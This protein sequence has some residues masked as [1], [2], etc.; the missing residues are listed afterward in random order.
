MVPYEKLTAEE[1]VAQQLIRFDW[2][3]KR[4]LRSKTNFGILEGF[5]SELL[6][7]DLK[8]LNILESEGNKD[9]KDIKFNKVDVLVELAG[10]EIVLI[11][12]K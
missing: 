6:K 8:I 1:K 4:L 11:E 10:G 9:D 5:L 2:A 3:M 12:Y 7:R